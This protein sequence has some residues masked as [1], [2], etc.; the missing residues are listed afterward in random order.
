MDTTTGPASQTE[1]GGLC[2]STWAP[3]SSYL[4]MINSVCEPMHDIVDYQ[5][6]PEVSVAVSRLLQA[7][8]ATSYPYLALKIQDLYPWGEL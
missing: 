6:Y 2:V 8:S 7:P 4:A 3:S 1:T 5:L